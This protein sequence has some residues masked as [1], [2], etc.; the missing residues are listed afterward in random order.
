MYLPTWRLKKKYRP[1]NLTL[2]KTRPGDLGADNRGIRMALNIESELTDETDWE[3][4]RRIQKPAKGQRKKEGTSDFNIE[5][6]FNVGQ[7]THIRGIY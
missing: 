2:E 7:Y 1:C 5:L 3:L 6:T 4:L